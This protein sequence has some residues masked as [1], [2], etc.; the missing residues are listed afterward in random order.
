MKAQIITI[1]DEILIG[2]II[3]TNSPFI[4]SLLEQNGVKVASIISISDTKEAIGE[5]LAASINTFDVTITT[6]GL[7]PTKDDITKSVLCDIFNCDMQLHEPTYKFIKERLEGI[8]IEFNELNQS[9]AYLPADAEVIKNNHGTAPA[10]MFE[11]N[12]KLLFSLPGV[13]FEM[14]QM[15]KDSVMDIIKSKLSLPIVYHKTAITYGLPESELAIK[16]ASWEDNLPSNIHLAYLPSTGRVRLRLS[17]IS[18]VD[19]VEAVTNKLFIELE[20]ILGSYLLG[21]DEATLESVVADILTERCETLAVAESCTGGKIASLFTAMEGASLYLKGGV[22]AYSNEVKV[23]IL[24]VDESIL[25]VHGA[26]S[27]PVAR[28]MAEGVRKALNSDYGVSTTGM[29]SPM[30]NTVKKTGEV[31]VAVS[32]KEGTI[33]KQFFFCELRDINIERFSSAAISMLRDELIRKKR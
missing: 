16:I 17:A 9:Q 4:A 3:D 11:K 27:E 22:V 8:G 25:E 33:S 32:S 31:W 15:V 19:D 26:V 23:S 28:L 12:G 5:A 2:Q 20:A 6:G 21:Y 18:L 7:G 13:P 29:A 24:G 1:G 14:K 10:L 30:P